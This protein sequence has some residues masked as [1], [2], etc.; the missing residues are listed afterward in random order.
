METTWRA[1]PLDA[2]RLAFIVLMSLLVVALAA[3]ALVV[4]SSLRLGPDAD[5]NAVPLIPKG[6][7]ALLPTAV[8]GLTGVV[9]LRTGGGHACAR[10]ADDTVTCWGQNDRGQLG[11]GVIGLADFSMQLVP[12]LPAPLPD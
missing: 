7:A 8:P 10:L 2:G 6:G 9:A 1:R 12:A 3:A 11:V 4:G 5:R